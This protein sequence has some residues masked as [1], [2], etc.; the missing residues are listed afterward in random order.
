MR[1]FKMEQKRRKDQWTAMDDEKLAEIVI[2]AVQNGR[3]QL[4]AFEQAARELNRTKQACGFRWNKTLRL[5]YGQVL[6]SVRKRP[7]QLMRSHLKLALSSF[8]EL[9]EAYNDLEIKHTELQSEYEKVLKWMQQG[10]NLVGDK[11]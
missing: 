1:W 6:N 8:E 3:T 10:V 5:Q 2:Q 7:K 4:E 9:T 11:K